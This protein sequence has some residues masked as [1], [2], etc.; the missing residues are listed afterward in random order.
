MAGLTVAEAVERIE[1]E[2]G[3]GETGARRPKA[4]ASAA[5]E[6]LALP[7]I[8][9]E[10]LK[11]QLGR[12]LQELDIASGWELP[13]KHDAVSSDARLC[14]LA[15]GG[16]DCQFQR[17]RRVDALEWSATGRP[18][19]AW[20]SLPP[21]LAAR[22]GSAAC[23]AADGAIMAVG[24]IGEKSA[25]VSHGSPLPAA[26]F[27][28]AV[29]LLTFMPTAAAAAD[30]SGGMAYAAADERRA[31]WRPGRSSVRRP[32]RSTWGQPAQRPAAPQ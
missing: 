22:C 32:C 8:E 10:G 30:G 11:A 3:L 16:W 18:A 25:E 13:D 1:D 6:Q 27:S 23:V 28:G 9:G 19:P 14:L 2:L 29:C 17:L 5:L 15:I 7:R 26:P 21:L 24:G 31:L 12:I 20:H 4:V